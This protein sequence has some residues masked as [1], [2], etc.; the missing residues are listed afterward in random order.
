MSLTITD[1]C[2]HNKQHL[3]YFHF[4]NVHSYGT[5]RDDRNHDACPFS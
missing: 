1:A 3:V 5:H 2:T 4:V